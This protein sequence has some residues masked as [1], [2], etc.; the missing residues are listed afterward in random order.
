[1]SRS[2]ASIRESNLFFDCTLTTDDDND[3]AYSDNLRAHKVILSASSEFFKKI[4]TKESLYANPNPVIYLRGI[5]AQDLTNILDFI[6]HGE[7]NVAKNELDK[8]FEV[9]CR[10]TEDS[11]TYPKLQIRDRDSWTTSGFQGLQEAI[12]TTNYPSSFSK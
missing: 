8:F 5:S 10:D 12:T 7:V 2:F 6:Y 11:G 9:S 3:E 1:M 4:L